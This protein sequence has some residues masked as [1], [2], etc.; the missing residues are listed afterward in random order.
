MTNNITAFKKI[1]GNRLKRKL[2]AAQKKVKGVAI[3]LTS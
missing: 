3:L 1:P 2:V